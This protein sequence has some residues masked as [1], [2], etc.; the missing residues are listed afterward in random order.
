MSTVEV[1]EGLMLISFSISWYW[2]IAKMLKSKVAA[3]KSL[4]FV[5]MICCGY[6]LGVSSKV[7]AWHETGVLSPL[8]W[9]YGWNLIV[10]AFDAVLVV[11][12]SRPTRE[13]SL[14]EYGMEGRASVPAVS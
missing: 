11:H 13:T 14:D 2:S 4:L 5:L 8:I 12:Y 7:L 1:L 3:G 6:V 10:T 9:V